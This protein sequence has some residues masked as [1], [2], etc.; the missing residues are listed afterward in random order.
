M[1]PGGKRLLLL[2]PHLAFGDRAVEG[3][4]PPRASLIFVIDVIALEKAQ[5]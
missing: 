5:R 1:R 4:I 2:P 3:I